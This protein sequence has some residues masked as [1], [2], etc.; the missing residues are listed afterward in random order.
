MTSVAG[1]RSRVDDVHDISLAVWALLA[2]ARAAGRHRAGPADAAVIAINLLAGSPAA[3]RRIRHRRRDPVALLA[4][5]AVVC[6]VVTTA[7][8]RSRWAPLA[9]VAVLIGLVLVERTRFPSRS[10]ATCRWLAGQ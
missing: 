5:A 8:P 10:V 4:P 7:R 1:D 3:L 2:S 6:A 9:T